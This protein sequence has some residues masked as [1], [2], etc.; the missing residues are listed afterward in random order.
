MFDTCLLNWYRTGAD[1]IG[2]HSDHEALGVLNAVVTVSLTF[3]HKTKGPNGRYAT[4][5][6][7]L[8]NTDLVLMAGCCQELWTHGI[9]K[10]DTD[11][12]RIS[13]TYR[14]IQE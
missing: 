13:L 8:N 6:V 2:M 14:L 11:E 3:I 5:K 12:S 1:K 10:E 4:I 7:P 9:N